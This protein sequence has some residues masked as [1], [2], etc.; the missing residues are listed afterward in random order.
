MV[1]YSLFRRVCCSVLGALILF[2]WMNTATADEY[3]TSG[4]SSGFFMSLEGTQ[5]FM[6]RDYSDDKFYTDT[7]GAKQCANGC[8]KSLKHSEIDFGGRI[9]LGWGKYFK[10]KYY[11]GFEAS[12]TK[13]GLNAKRQY[14]NVAVGL[15]QSLEQDFS[16]QLVLR[17]GYRL[18]EGDDAFLRLGMERGDFNYKFSSIGLRKAGGHKNDDKS[19][20]YSKSEWEDAWVLGFDREVKTS[21]QTAL[22]L[23]WEYV[24]Y[25]TLKHSHSW[26]PTKNGEGA[27]DGSLAT[28]IQ[29]QNVR[30]D[31][32]VTTFKLGMVWRPGDTSEPPKGNYHDFSGFYG[33]I[34][35]GYVG[36]EDNMVVYNGDNM[37]NPHDD[38]VG[39]H[40]GSAGFAMGFGKQ[41]NRLYLGAEASYGYIDNRAKNIT[42]EGSK[43]EID[44]SSQS[45][46]WVYTSEVENKY[47]TDVAMRIGYLLAPKSMFYTKLGYVRAKY[48][49]T[50]Y[51]T[52]INVVGK[53]GVI[54]PADDISKYTTLPEGSQS[55][56]LNGYRI[57]AG[58]DT[59]MGNNFI[60]RTEWTH[61]K[62]NKINLNK[63]VT[64]SNRGGKIEP[65][66]HRFNVGVIYGF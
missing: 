28:N 58:I 39:S 9:G 8:V 13:S 36:N 3:S 53:D 30:Q 12:A 25:G 18:S 66:R 51:L 38:R 55:K 47:E 10:D 6:H 54:G 37:T 60:F 19:V 23:G 57:G 22:R 52:G 56:T 29:D 1:V 43:T 16:Y 11:L 17:P 31:V 15:K 48:K 44:G 62:F 34:T 20:H 61:S 21:S 24:D 26:T 33:G 35:G 59:A 63:D 41:W 27:G 64:I 14:E 65:E 40:T 45:F 4:Y 50:R 49:F 42:S 5:S 7:N 46:E 32:S 2:G